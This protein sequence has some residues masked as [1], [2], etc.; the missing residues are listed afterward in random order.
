MPEN[1]SVEFL[2]KYKN[3]VA[4]K[5]IRIT[6]GT[7]PEEIVLQLS[8]IRQ[9]VDRKSF[10]ILGIDVEAM[11]EYATELTK[12]TRKSLRGARGGR[13]EARHQGGQGEC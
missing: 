9:S 8:G 5:K 13:A 3:W 2:A 7:V 4:V 1:D 12:G 11:D 6:E 10:E